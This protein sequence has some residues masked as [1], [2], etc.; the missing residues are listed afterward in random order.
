MYKAR[1]GYSLICSKTSGK[2]CD[3]NG[4]VV[5]R[6]VQKHATNMLKN[7]ACLGKNYDKLG[8]V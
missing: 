3:K 2:K 7:F 8:I 6:Y 5:D 4:I 1:D